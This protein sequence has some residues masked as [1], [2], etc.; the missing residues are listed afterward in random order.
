[1]SNENKSKVSKQIYDLCKAIVEY[2]KYIKNPKD[3]QFNGFLIKK[4]LIETLKKNI[5]YDKF[6]EGIR[7]INYDYKTLK[8]NIEKVCG[9]KE[10]KT[11]INQTVF[12]NSN[13]LIKELDTNQFHLIN[14]DL[15]KVIRKKGIVNDKGVSFK[16]DSKEI[17][18]IFNENDKLKFKNNKFIISK[19][20]LIENQNNNINEKDLIKTDSKKYNEKTSSNNKNSINNNKDLKEDKKV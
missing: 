17:T 20:T 8:A 10:I 19:E 4:E 2:E 11:N 16:C 13:D 5:F 12:Q 18:L 14:H 6:E 7:L 9:T 15:Y 3:S 1:M